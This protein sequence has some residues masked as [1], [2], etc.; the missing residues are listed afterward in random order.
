MPQSEQCI[1]QL[2]IRQFCTTMTFQ[3][4]PTMFFCS[5]VLAISCN[6]IFQ[7]FLA[8]LVV[9]ISQFCYVFLAQNTI[10]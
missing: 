8:T 4:I 10:F 3:Q 2:L 1:V 9:L 5:M 6:N 7:A